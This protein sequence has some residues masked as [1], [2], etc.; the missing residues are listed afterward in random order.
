MQY[1][2][3]MCVLNSVNGLQEK[4]TSVTK[5]KLNINK[6]NMYTQKVKLFKYL[7]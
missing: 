5:T 7:C 4:L 2:R 1:E 6:M 3:D